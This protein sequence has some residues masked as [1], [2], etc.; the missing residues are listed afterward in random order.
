MYL[1]GYLKTGLSGSLRRAGG[2]IRA[3]FTDTN[4]QVIDA[5]V[6]VLPAPVIQVL[7][8]QARGGVSLESRANAAR[9][10]G[11]PAAAS[12]PLPIS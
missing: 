5:Y 2:S 6:E 7:G 8:R 9:A 12:L 3:K 10:L 1:P 4:D 11:I